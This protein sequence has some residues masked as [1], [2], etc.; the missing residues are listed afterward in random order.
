MHLKDYRLQE[1]EVSALV[2]IPVEEGLKLFTNE[3][4]VVNARG[5]RLIKD[6]FEEFE[7]EVSQDS[8]IPRKK[9]Y[10]YYKIFL[11]ADLYLKGLKKL[12]I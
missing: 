2:E 9:D 4:N 6:N 11:M 7:M 8:V 3:K 1:D 12:A 10:F 5:V